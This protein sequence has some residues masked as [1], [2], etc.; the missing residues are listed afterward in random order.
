MGLAR[1]TAERFLREAKVED[2]M[3]E[4]AVASRNLG[5]TC[6]W[7]GDFTEANA[8]LEEALRLGDAQ[9][10]S[11]VSVSFGHDTVAA[12]KAF[13]ALTTWLLG[14]VTRARELIEQA[15]AR[16]VETG[17]APTLVNA[18]CYKAEPPPN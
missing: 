11:K 7:Q 17:H 6:F 2:R 10:D 14:E 15:I 1:Q 8:H 16:G 9:H 12:A 18:Y 3:V 4:A 5:L 13:L